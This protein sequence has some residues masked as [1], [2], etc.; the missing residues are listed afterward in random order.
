MRYFCPLPH[1]RSLPDTLKVGASAILVMATLLGIL[2]GLIFVE[3]IEKLTRN[4]KGD[5]RK[6]DRRTCHKIAEGYQGMRDEQRLDRPYHRIQVAGNS[7]QHV[8]H[9]GGR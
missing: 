6:E 1:R 5:R 4:L 9:P 8:T 7:F 3:G 2:L